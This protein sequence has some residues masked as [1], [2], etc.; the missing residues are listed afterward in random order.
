MEMKENSEHSVYIKDLTMII[1]KDVKEME[2]V[3]Q[4]GNK[5]KAIGET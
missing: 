4:I 2:N 3:M 1:V 5:N